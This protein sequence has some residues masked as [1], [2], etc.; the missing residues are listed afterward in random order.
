MSAQHIS[1]IAWWWREG[2]PGWAP[3]ARLQRPACTQRRMQRQACAQP[4]ACTRALRRRAPAAAGSRPG[5]ARGAAAAAAPA[6]ARAWAGGRPTSRGRWGWWRPGCLLGVRGRRGEQAEV[7][8]FVAEHG[9]A[10]APGTSCIWGRAG[11]VTVQQC[12]GPAR[13]R[14]GPH[15]ARGARLTCERCGR[16]AKPRAQGAHARAVAPHRW[17]ARA[18]PVAAAAT[19][20]NPSPRPRA[21]SPAAWA[22]RRAPAAARAAAARPAAARPP[23]RRAARGER[24]GARRCGRWRRPTRRAG[25]ACGGRGR[26]A[27]PASRRAPEAEPLGKTPPRRSA[28]PKPPLLPPPPVVPASEARA[29]A[30]PAA[31]AP[32]AGRRFAGSASGGRA[33]SAFARAMQACPRLHG[34]GPKPPPQPAHANRKPAHAT[35]R[36]ARLERHAPHRPA[37][38]RPGHRTRGPA[39][40][41]APAPAGG[42]PAARAPRWTRRPRAPRRRA[43]AAARARAGRGGTPPRRR[44]RGSS[45]AL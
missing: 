11:A 1:M 33:A 18:G 17:I 9:A 5:A 34:M 42:C 6:P 39:A 24:R 12:S 44:C 36:A 14:I 37:R 22:R 28:A 15:A 16:G 26:G 7:V 10:G 32:A 30:P 21:S 25:S 2:R 27:P 38:A 19:R 23:P 40:P 29:A 3:A 4:R 20:G 8:G 41:A 31:R 35:P 13:G 43:A 45:I